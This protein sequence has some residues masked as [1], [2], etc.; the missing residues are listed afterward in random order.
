MAGSSQ[1]NGFFGAYLKFCGFDGI[2]FQGKAPHLVY[3]LLRG[4]PARNP[5]CPAPGRQ[6]RCRD[7]A[8]LKAELR[9]QKARA[10]VFGIGPA[11]ENRVRHACIVGDG[12]HAAAHNGLGA[13]MG[14]KNLKAVVACKSKPHF[15]RLR[16]RPS[17]S[18]SRKNWSK[19]QNHRRRLLQMG[20]RRRF[21]K[22]A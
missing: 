17:Q 11:G 7:G 8:L 21:F 19:R 9:A 20:D 22:P 4:R 6:N 2:V 16:S 18:K 5:R 3:L 14:A 13:V 1:A 12:G 15:R 10:S